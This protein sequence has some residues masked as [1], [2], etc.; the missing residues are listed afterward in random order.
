MSARPIPLG[1]EPSGAVYDG[2][3]LVGLIFDTAGGCTATL[4]DRQP[5]GVFKNWNEA[6]TAIHEARTA[7]RSGTNQEVAA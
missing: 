3:D 7:L 2:R 5:I 1:R 6:R 4:T